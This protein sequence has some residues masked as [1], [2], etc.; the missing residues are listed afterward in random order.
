[1]VVRFNTCFIGGFEDVE[2]PDNYRD[3]DIRR[4]YEAWLL[5]EVGDGWEDVTDEYEE[6]ED[7]DE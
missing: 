1:M 4:E 6:E 5:T 2:I 3:E 7:D